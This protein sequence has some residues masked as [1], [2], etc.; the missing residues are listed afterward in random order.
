LPL[1]SP[2]Q[3]RRNGRGPRD[4]QAVSVNSSGFGRSVRDVRCEDIA[5]PQRTTNSRR[6]D[7]RRTS[8]GRPLEG[9][10]PRNPPLRVRRS[11][12]ILGL[13]PQGT[14]RRL[15]QQ[16]HEVNASANPSAKAQA[17]SNATMGNACLEWS[18]ARHGCRTCRRSMLRQC[19]ISGQTG[20][21]TRGPERIGMRLGRCGCSERAVTPGGRMCFLP[22]RV[23]CG[24]GGGDGQYTSTHVLSL[25]GQFEG[26][27]ADVA[28]DSQ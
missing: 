9:L 21:R 12:E 7:S 25:R 15:L 27:R 17:V 19:Q 8:P 10:R 22:A 24:A 13:K 23:A 6:I 1:C 26:G 16:A 3:K 5:C 11:K 14:G 18:R 4:R 20:D 2:T 28:L